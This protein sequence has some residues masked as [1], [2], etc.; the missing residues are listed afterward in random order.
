MY[1]SFRNSGDKLTK[2]F[3]NHKEYF[4]KSFSV[5]DDVKYTEVQQP[6]PILKKKSSPLS[7]IREGD[8]DAKIEMSSEQHD[9]ARSHWKSAVGKVSQESGESETTFTNQG[10]EDMP[11]TLSEGSAWKKVKKVQLNDSRPTTLSLRED[12]NGSPEHETFYL[13]EGQM[14]QVWRPKKNPQLANL[15]TNMMKAKKQESRSPLLATPSKADLRSRQKTLFNRV[16]ATQAVLKETTDE[17]LYEEDEDEDDEDVRAKRKSRLTLHAATKKISA[18]L[19]RQKS[20]EKERQSI[21]DVVSQ[22]LAKARAEPATVQD[23]IQASPGGNFSTQKTVRRPAETPGAIPLK[24][25]REIVRE[26][27]DL[28]KH[29]D[30]LANSTSPQVKKNLRSPGVSF[31]QTVP[32]SPAASTPDSQPIH[33]PIA[34]KDSRGILKKSK[35]AELKENAAT[36]RRQSYQ[37]QDPLKEW[38]ASP[39]ASVEEKTGAEITANGDDNAA[40]H[41]NGFHNPAPSAAPVTSLPSVNGNSNNNNNKSHGSTVIIHTGQKQSLDDQFPRPGSPSYFGE[42]PPQ[43][44]TS[45]TDVFI[46]VKQTSPNQSPLT[47]LSQKTRAQ[48]RVHVAENTSESY[49]L[50]EEESS[51]SSS[52]SS[53]QTDESDNGTSWF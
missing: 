51:R 35:M 15:V 13:H 29:A 49:S 31:V 18:N 20:A 22:Y 40:V 25:W 39:K 6:V 14:H 3:D 12:D 38:S 42:K 48:R 32:V 52:S 16:Q 46:S 19:L 53:S 11:R 9:K 8:E 26:N 21:S 28:G 2:Q 34:K 45:P 1:N 37:R 30:S 4:E 50:R 33:Q 47:K 23:E 7:P 36:A 41:V 44:K 27:K 10:S 5:E 43:R 24:K 17:I